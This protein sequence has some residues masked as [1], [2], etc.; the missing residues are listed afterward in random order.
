MRSALNENLDQVS[1]DRERFSRLAQCACSAAQ[2]IGQT[3]V[4]QAASMLAERAREWTFQLIFGG[5]F[6]SGKSTAINALLGQKV[7]PTDVVE[8]S[9]IL[10]YIRHGSA[11]RA[12]LY[13][14]DGRAPVE[15]PVEELR[16]HI[17]VDPDDPDRELPWKY[18]ELYLPLELLKQGVVVVD[19]PGTNNQDERTRKNIEAT[20]GSDAVVYLFFAAVGLTMAQ[21]PRVSADLAGKEC[22]W[23]VTHADSLHGE[24]AEEKVRKRL[25]SDLRKVRPSDES[26]ESRIYFVN[27][28]KAQEAKANQNA[29]DFTVSGM[30][31]FETALGEFIAGDRHR[32]KMVTLCCD[33]E[34]ILARLD[35][36]A[37]ERE[38]A[39]QDEWH[40]TQDE[41]DEAL[42]KLRILRGDISD[43]EVNLMCTV[44]RLV[45]TVP[46]SVCMGVAQLPLNS[47][48]ISYGSISAAPTVFIGD[49]LTNKSIRD[50]VR[51]NVVTS[52]REYLSSWF[53][54]EFAS[55]IN[56]QIGAE[57]N[58]FNDKLHAFKESLTLLQRSMNLPFDQLGNV[59][60][61][62]VIPVGGISDAVKSASA[63]V[64]TPDIS[65]FVG[66]KAA[67]NWWSLGSSQS[68]W[69]WDSALDL[70]KED[71]LHRVRR[72]VLGSMADQAKEI[73]D[74]VVRALTGWRMQIDRAGTMAIVKPLLDLDETEKAVQDKATAAEATKNKRLQEFAKRREELRTLHSE[75][76]E[77]QAGYATR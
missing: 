37:G 64:G 48:E 34:E 20:Q 73:A 62:P 72:E 58:T 41:C 71:F 46:L 29:S 51:S 9:A 54:E 59:A 6:N 52:A 63:R 75:L 57:T 12:L 2:E 50:E 21:R 28:L 14:L 40:R 55:K 17:I 61:M 33:L 66:S 39:I 47:S 42:K 49:G 38:Q 68:E 76:A 77:V 69:D 11:G 43:A 24:D 35:E 67:A 70:A 36:F 7:M 19:P 15:I 26:V 18:A 1:A 25:V 53:D 10:T 23:L 65:G 56:A 13:P 45:A 30:H 32:A 22:F 3:K 27:A 8:A 60:E 44:E 5:E 74:D 31:D 16:T 4:A